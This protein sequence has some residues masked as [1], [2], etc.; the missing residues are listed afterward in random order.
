MQPDPKSSGELCLDFANTLRFHASEQPVETL[1]SYDDLVV[2]ARKFN[3]LTP[4]E[5]NQLL[6]EAQ[7]RTGESRCVLDRGIKLRE[8]IYRIIMSYMDKHSPAPDD[9]NILNR[10]LELAH[11]FF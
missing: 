8:A 1:A 11:R 7:D 3:I 9:L 6:S 5:E 10:E 4:R 2:W